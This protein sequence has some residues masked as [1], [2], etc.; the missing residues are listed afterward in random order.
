MDAIKSS[1]TSLMSALDFNRVSVL[2]AGRGATPRASRRH[3]CARAHGAQA[4]LS[5]ALDII[6]VSYPDGSIKSTPF[7][8]RFGKFKVCRA[9]DAWGCGGEPRAL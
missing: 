9:V 6:A 3:V 8:V 4:T 1:Y 7:H 2:C 5:G